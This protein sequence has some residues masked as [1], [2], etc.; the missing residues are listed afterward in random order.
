[1]GQVERHK[2]YPRVP[3]S[4]I[5][6]AWGNGR[7]FTF[8]TETDAMNISQCGM[9]GQGIGFEIIHILMTSLTCEE[10]FWYQ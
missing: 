5:S 10:K 3:T 1:V 4:I 7:T 9:W 2:G 8:F 6:Y